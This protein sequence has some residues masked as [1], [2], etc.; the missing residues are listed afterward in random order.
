MRSILLTTYIILTLWSL[1]SIILHGTRPAKSMAWVFT[2]LVFPFAGPL[3]YYL[4]GLNRRK[5]K[6]YELKKS[7][8]RKLYDDTQ[9]AKAERPD[10]LEQSPELNQKLVRVIINSSSTLPKTGNSVTVLHTGEATFESIFRAIQNASKFIHLQY[11]EFE[12]GTLYERF[13]ELFKQ[14]ISEGVEVRMIYDSF[15]SSSFRGASK[16]RFLSIGVKAYPMMPLRLGSLMYTLNYRN[17]RKILVVDGQIAFTGGMNVSDKYIAPVSELGIWQDLHLALEGPV[18][19]SLHHIFCKDYYFAS[20]EKLLSDEKYH[21]SVEKM[22]D[23]TVQIVSSGPDSDQPAIMQQYVAMI[24]EA[25]KKVCIANPYFVPGTVVLQALKICAQSGV[26]VH[27]LVPESSDSFLAKYSMFSNFEEFLKLGIRVYLRKDFSHSKVIIIDD[28]IASVGSGNFDY[29]SF[30]HNF[31]TNA[32]IYDAGVAAEISREF[33][34]ECEKA[35]SLTY[36][37]FKKRSLFKKFLEGIARFFS[38]LL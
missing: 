28:A 26:E 1:L 12:E 36:D 10:D 2:V 34:K 3:I 18:V 21:G 33:E 22:G 15:G 6:F 35:Q 30:E 14:K 38:P 32:V 23:K 24:H 20:R 4:F 7:K 5:F 29:R 8:E 37:E 25:Q 19:S 13:Y 11:Y 27:L 17:H 31:E 16:K 9:L